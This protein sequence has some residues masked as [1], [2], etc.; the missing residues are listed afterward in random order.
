MPVLKKNIWLVF[1]ALVLTG[2]ILLAYISYVRWYDIKESLQ[3]QQQYQVELVKNSVSSVLENQ[4]ILL[5]VIGS[6]ITKDVFLNHP[7]AIRSLFDEQLRLNPELAGIGVSRPDG[8]PFIVSKNLR[9]LPRLNLSTAKETS[10]SFK[11]AL[12]SQDVVIG[13]TYYHPNLKEWIIPIR[14]SLRTQEGELYGLVA[15]G[16]YLE[17][18]SFWSS[19][20]HINP[21]HQLSVVRDSDLYFQFYSSGWNNSQQSYNKPLT[22]NSFDTFVQRS[23]EKYQISEFELRNG[24]TQIS[25]EYNVRGDSVFSDIRFNPDLGLWFVSEMKNSAVWDVFYHTFWIYCLIFGSTL[26]I[27]FFL[28]KLIYQADKKRHQALVY[29][30]HHDKLTA[31]PNRNYI[32]YKEAERFEKPDN[33][34]SII[35][36]DMDRFKNIN[37]SYGH[38]FGDKVLIEITRRLKVSCN[39]NDLIARLSGDEFLILTSETNPTELT[40]KAKKIIQTLCEPYDINKQ[41]FILGASA[42]IA[43]YPAHGDNLEAVL[44]SADLAMFDAKTLKSSVSFFDPIMMNDHIDRLKIEQELHRGLSESEFYMVYQPKIDGDGKVYGVEALVRWKNQ[45][46]GFVPPDRFISVAESCGLIPA[47]GEFII[48]TTLT[49][50]ASLQK[51]IDFEFNVAINISVQQFF[52]ANFVDLLEQEIAGRNIPYDKITL[53]ITESLFIED[54][55]ALLLI[56]QRIRSLGMEISLDDFGTGF[57]SLGMLRRLPIDELK[58]DKSFVD[59]ILTE[60]PARQM[61]QSIIAISQNYQMSVIAEGVEEIEQAQLLKDFGCYHFQGYHF[62]RPLPLDELREF[63]IHNRAQA[64]PVAD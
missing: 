12:V 38:K 40:S 2:S 18:T 9:Q 15:V 37:D 27:I 56:L 50:I 29:Q 52:H 30:A 39:S 35:F 1:Y 43:Q 25:L 14:K 63:I 4:S 8:T 16:V 13:R 60:E 45:Q 20:T 6:Q 44:S 62:A 32:L 49:D 34:F 21:H 51:E 17:G 48:K 24:S 3:K 23:T 61:V 10:E 54:I 19:A 59:N 36:I 53:E 41:H 47:L 42:G 22:Q 58:I 46:L 31:L 7:D 28:F 57:S 5:R 26:V 11:R 64:S 55:D 33:P